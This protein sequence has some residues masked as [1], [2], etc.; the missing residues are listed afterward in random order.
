M[1]DI[2]RSRSR[3]R[4]SSGQRWETPV[5]QCGPEDRLT[6]AQRARTHRRCSYMFMKGTAQVQRSYLER[7]RSGHKRTLKKAQACR[8]IHVFWVILHLN[9]K[10]DGNLTPMTS[11]SLT[12]DG[13]QVKVRSNNVKFWNQYVRTFR[14]SEFSQDSE[15]V[16]CFLWLM[17]SKI[18]MKKYVMPFR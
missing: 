17:I 1:L 7:L 6:G 13:D 8:A 4:S 11:S 16:I 12:F 18:A 14:G 15:Y 3:V 10:S 2:P 5:S 9:N